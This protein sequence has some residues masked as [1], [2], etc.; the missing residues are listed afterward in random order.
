M[1]GGYCQN[2]AVGLLN[3]GLAEERRKLVVSRENRDNHL[4]GRLAGSNR[5]RLS[6][7]LR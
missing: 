1:T 6:G 2:L 7:I 5:R 4:S 3:D